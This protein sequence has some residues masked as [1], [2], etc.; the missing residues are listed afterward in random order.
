M[1]VDPVYIL[2][3]PDAG[4]R[5]AFVDELAKAMGPGVE[6]HRL[7][8]EETEV[9]ELLALAM[10][11]SLFSESKLIEYRGA[12]LAKSKD[13]VATLAAYAARPAEGA[14]LLLVT[15]AFGLDKILEEV[16]GKD[17]KKTFY[18]L[19]ENE[20]PRWI[21][22]R[23]GESGIDIDDAAIEVLLELIENDTAALDTVCARL[24]I[25]FPRG[26]RLGADEIDAAIARNRQ[27]DAFSLFARIAADEPAW[28]LECLEAVLAD[29]Q[30]GAVQLIAALVWSWRRLLRLHILIDGG[31]SFDMA[32]VKSGIKAKSLQALHREALARYSR[33]DCSAVIALLAEFD[34]RARGSGAQLERGLLQLLVYGIMIKKGRLRLDASWL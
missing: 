2:A 3:G 7:Y 8:A 17:R 18:E 28:A 14:V 30:G 13:E 20:K 34:A 11:G 21:A 25:L 29:R 27:E 15:E 32:C 22:R 24:A 9:G 6:R 16:I 12:E 23:L 4:R 5:A 10:N 31:E 26:S 1:R 33:E 19:F